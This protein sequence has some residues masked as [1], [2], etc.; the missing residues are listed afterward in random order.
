M[1]KFCLMFI[2]VELNFF[3]K[4]YLWFGKMFLWE[5]KKEEVKVWFEKVVNSNLCKIVDDKMVCILLS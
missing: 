3:S 2:L 4:N 5:N 1:F